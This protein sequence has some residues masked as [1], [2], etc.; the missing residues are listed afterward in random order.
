ML[1]SVSALAMLCAYP[2][3]ALAPVAST[4]VPGYPPSPRAP[5]GAP[6]VLIIM[7]DDVGF[8]ASSTFGGP[9]PTLTFDA[10]AAQ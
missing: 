1:A 6:N 3:A 2:A 7:T 4:T 5:Q 9:I 8:A 10:L